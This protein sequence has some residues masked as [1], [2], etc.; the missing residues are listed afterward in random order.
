MR[1][2][3]TNRDGRAL[4]RKLKLMTFSPNWEI[5]L[6]FTKGGHYSWRQFFLLQTVE[7]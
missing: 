4:A 5:R 7:C 2:V 1:L 3:G 6:V